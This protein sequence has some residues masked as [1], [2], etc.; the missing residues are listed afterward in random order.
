LGGCG[1]GAQ[2]Q[3]CGCHGHDTAK[4]WGLHGDS[5][6]WAAKPGG[7]CGELSEGFSGYGFH[8][9]DDL[10][11]PISDGIAGVPGCWHSPAERSGALIAQGIDLRK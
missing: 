7:L 6:G 3:S 11:S 4:R 1:G 9:P 5:W 2:Q 8:F 10:S